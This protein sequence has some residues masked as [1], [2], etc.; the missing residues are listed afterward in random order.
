MILISFCWIYA[1]AWSILPYFGF[2]RYIPEGILDSCSFD[3]LTRDTMVSFIIIIFFQQFP[4]IVE[5]LIFRLRRSDSVYS[6]SC[7]A[8]HWAS[9]FSATIS[10]LRLFSNT[11]KL[12]A[13]KQR[14]WT[15]HPSALMLMLMPHL[16]K[17]E[18]Q[19]WLFV[20]LP[21]GQPCGHLTPPSSSR[22]S[23]VFGRSKLAN[24]THVFVWYRD[25][26]VTNLQS[27]HWLPSCQPWLLNQLLSAIQWSTLFLI[28]N[29]EW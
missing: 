24:H 23:G 28:Q 4:F 8:P 26:W 14:R 22:Y 10:S 11:K 6:S 13:N 1:T 18:S 12:F 7:T 3:Y 16:L 17:S 20:T 5:N 27:L 19:R 29:S 9:S 21:C 25:F 15:S 2:G